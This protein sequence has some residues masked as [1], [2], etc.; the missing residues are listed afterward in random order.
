MKGIT[1]LIALFTSFVALQ[2]QA[3][4]ECP[5]HQ[6]KISEIKNIL[7]ASGLSEGGS[8][9]FN[10]LAG[11][12][13]APHNTL[14][15][16]GGAVAHGVDVLFF[17]HQLLPEAERTDWATAAA[18]LDPVLSHQDD[19]MVRFSGVTVVPDFGSYQV[20]L[21]PDAFNGR[22]SEPNMEDGYQPVFHRTRLVFNRSFSYFKEAT[23]DLVEWDGGIF[24]SGHDDMGQVLFSSPAD[25]LPYETTATVTVACAPIDLLDFNPEFLFNC[26]NPGVYQLSYRIEPGQGRLEDVPERLLCGKLVCAD[27]RDSTNWDDRSFYSI[28]E[29]S[30]LRD[31]PPPYSRW[32][33]APGGVT[34]VSGEI[35]RACELVPSVVMAPSSCGADFLP[36]AN[37]SD[38]DEGDIIVLKGL[39][40]TADSNGNYLASSAGQYLARCAGCVPGVPSGSPDNTAVHVIDPNRSV[41]QW[42]VKKLANGK[43]ALRADTGKYL[44]RCRGC[45]PGVGGDSAFVHVSDPDAPFAQFTIEPAAQAGKF[46]LRSDN[47]RYLSPC[48]GCVPGQGK[49]GLKYNGSLHLTDPSD[50]FAAWEI[51]VRQKDRIDP[52]I[53]SADRT[54]NADITVKSSEIWVIDPGEVV[55]ISFGATLFIENGA[56]IENN[57]LII[58]NGSIKVGELGEVINQGIIANKEIIRLTGGLIDNRSSGIIDNSDANHIQNYAGIIINNGGIYDPY[59]RYYGINPAI[60]LPVDG[61]YLGPDVVGE[62]TCL[63]IGGVSH[64]WEDTAANPDTCSIDSFWLR[65][66]ETLAIA[67]GVT[68]NL[69]GALNNDGTIINDGTINNN[70]RIRDCGFFDSDGTTGSGTVSSPAEGCTTS[71]EQIKCE[72]YGGSF[73]PGANVNTGTCERVNGVPVVAGSTLKIPAGVTWN[74]TSDFEIFGS[75]IIEEGGAL[76]VAGGGGAGATVTNDSNQIINYGTLTVG[77]DDSLGFPFILQNDGIINNYGVINNDGSITGAGDIQNYCGAAYNLLGSGTEGEFQQIGFFPCPPPDFDNDGVEDELDAFPYDSTETTDTDGDGTGD[78]ADVFPLNARES[79]DTDG[80]CG[81][82]TTQTPTSGDGCGDSSDLFPLNALE[83]ADTDG[84]CSIVVSETTQTPTLGNGCGDNSD[85][86]PLNRLEIADLDGDCGIIALQSLTSGNGCGDYSD[87]FPGNASETR[88]SDRD[89]VGDNAD[90]FPNDADDTRLVSV[91][92]LNGW[93]LEEGLFSTSAQQESLPQGLPSGVELPFGIVV[94]QLS[95]GAIGTESVITIQYPAPLDPAMVWWKYGPTIS[96]NT[97]HWYIFDGA[98]I[99]GDT[100]TLTIEDGGPGDDD[101]IQDG[102]ITDPGGPGMPQA[103]GITDTPVTGQPQSGSGGGSLNLWFLLLLSSLYLCKRGRRDYFLT[104]IRGAASAFLLTN[105]KERFPL[106]RE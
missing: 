86:F 70:G 101:L 106:S 50:V 89:G 40:A 78:V 98:V 63:L 103:T 91:D 5:V 28:T 92:S 71:P 90:G 41:A 75:V 93:S 99:S 31:C 80:D 51:S 35:Y 16:I 30:D 84:D 105:Y 102:N 104:N 57:G 64:A 3:A 66:G 33:G 61:F 53:Y 81:I 2:T 19:L 97:P 25:G 20:V 54:F 8:I 6:L 22:S 83:Q 27:A 76:A 23:F 11:L 69:D 7:P 79:A 9:L 96:D 67:S 21:D 100:V 14:A 4:E 85:A 1:A 44:A 47:A 94:L 43:F 29:E 39:T 46:T 15:S 13:F 32:T 52:V 56:S 65:A 62:R 87:A 36:L 48:L 59:N 18:I 95:D 77:R 42:T 34:E 88:D 17:D 55:T 72:A 38:L 45:I 37:V 74:V 58:N 26:R 10:G 73:N 68:L 24:G 12:T 60:N 49:P 82:I